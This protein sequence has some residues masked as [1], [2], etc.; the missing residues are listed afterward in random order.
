[1]FLKRK[2]G[3]KKGVRGGRVEGH[4]SSTKKNSPRGGENS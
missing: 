2:G 4:V 3:E 1:M